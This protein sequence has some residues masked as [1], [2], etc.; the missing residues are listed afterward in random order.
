MYLYSFACNDM[1]LLGQKDR[2]NTKFS[3]SRKEVV[4]KG[5]GTKA[6]SCHIHQSPAIKYGLIE[7]N[8]VDF[9]LQELIG[10]P[11]ETAETVESLRRLS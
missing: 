10:E 5:S 1:Q 4:L 2:G 7:D 6:L 3:N 11:V 9:D 8:Y